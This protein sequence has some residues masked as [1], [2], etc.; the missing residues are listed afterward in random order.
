MTSEWVNIDVDGLE[1]RAFLSRPESPGPGVLVLQE[2]FGVNAHI[3][4]VCRRLASAGFTALAPELYHRTAPHLALGYNS[5]DVAAGR[6]HKERVQQ[7]ELVADLAASAAELSRHSAGRP[8]GVMG[9]CF[10]GFCTVV[11]MAT[12][13]FAAGVAFYGGGLPQGT[14]GIPSPL[15]DL[16]E[17]RGELLA[18]FG[19]QDPLIPQEDVAML[20][21]A[22]ETA[23]VAHAVQVFEEASH[24]FFCNLRSSYHP[25]AAGRAWEL[26]LEVLRRR[27]LGGG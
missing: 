24:G 27:L 11:A 8:L 22:L 16:S 19:G 2:I 4:D 12:L 20:Q 18:L 14:A 7:E 21:D 15:G 13:P 3:Q 25:E 9:F 17:V 6:S 26:T 5:D 23:G 1:M 10:G